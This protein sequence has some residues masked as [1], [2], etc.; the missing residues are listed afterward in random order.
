MNI[1]ELKNTSSEE[2][3]A[4]AENRRAPKWVPIWKWVESFYP[5]VWPTSF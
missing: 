4:K 1:Q 5:K 2:L 3:I